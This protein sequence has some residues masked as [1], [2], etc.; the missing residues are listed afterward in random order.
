MA[1]WVGAR[2]MLWTIAIGQVVAVVAALVTR[3]L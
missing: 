2:G 3:S 1:A